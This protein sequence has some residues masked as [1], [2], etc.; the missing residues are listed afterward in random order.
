MGWKSYTLN[1]AG[2]LTLAK[3]TLSNISS[4]VM[5]YIKILE[6]VAKSMDKIIREFLWGSSEDKKKLYLLNWDT[7]TQPKDLGGLGLQNTTLRNKAILSGFAWRVKHS[8][9][10]LWSSVLKAKYRNNL[11]DMTNRQSVS[12]SWKNIIEGWKNI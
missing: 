3:A 2:R 8:R 7:I 12:R 4:H 11:N 10:S 5:N 1:M 6:S 9:N